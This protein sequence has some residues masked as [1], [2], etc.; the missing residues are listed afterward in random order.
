ME[1]AHGFSGG[2]CRAVVEIWGC[3]VRGA[4]ELAVEGGFG[5]LGFQDEALGVFPSRLRV[6]VAASTPL[7]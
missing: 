2:S 6:A 4:W 5:I 3:P 7:R 1:R